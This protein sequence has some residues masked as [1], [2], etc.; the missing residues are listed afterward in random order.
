MNRNSKTIDI[1]TETSR[2]S[3]EIDDVLEEAEALQTPAGCESSTALE[4]SDEYEELDIQFKALNVQKEKLEDSIDRMGGSE[5]EIQELSFGELMMVR[6]EVMAV[7][8][9]GSPREGLYQVKVLEQAVVSSPAEC[10]DAP[11]NW[12]P[13]VAEYVYD[14]VDA[15]NSGV[16][17]EN[18]GQYSLADAME[19]K[20]R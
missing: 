16:S 9:E 7:S 14:E 10:P 13:A 15:M 11:E 5:F 20:D 2:L 6:D 3:D 18:L 12:Q 19:E 8:D 4:S 17:E 1:S